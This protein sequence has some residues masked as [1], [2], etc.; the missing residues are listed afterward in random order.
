MSSGCAQITITLSS[1][2]HVSI[3]PNVPLNIPELVFRAP[4]AASSMELNSS[5]FKLQ[6]TEG[7]LGTIQ[8]RLL[9]QLDLYL[10]GDSGV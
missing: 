8:I 7:T 4:G 1:S 5:A 2:L 10:P 9:I 6:W 3:R